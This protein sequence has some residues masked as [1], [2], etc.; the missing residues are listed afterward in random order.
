MRFLMKA[1]TAALPTQSMLMR[2]SYSRDISR[3]VPIGRDSRGF[4]EPVLKGNPELSDIGKFKAL[5]RW[6]GSQSDDR[7]V[8]LFDSLTS[9]SAFGS[10]R[11]RLPFSEYRTVVLNYAMGEP[12][13]IYT[14]AWFGTLLHL[15]GAIRHRPNATLDLFYD[16]N[17]GEEP[18]VQAGYDVFYRWIVEEQP[19]IAA[20]LPRRPT[21]RND[22]A[23]WPLRA[24][25]ALAWNAH[26]AF[27]M[28]K[29]GKRF[30]NPLW[31]A[32][33]GGP[34]GGRCNLGRT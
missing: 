18:K 32:L 25:D 23:V 9:D 19:A 28:D 6:E 12:E 15:L 33:D 24:A 22:T 34:K 5:V 27:L 14:F 31:R 8:R 30:S 17:M 2:Y 13:N 7:I 1:A 10:V 3:L 11:W 26:R 20:M 29:K 21:P 4:W 16:E